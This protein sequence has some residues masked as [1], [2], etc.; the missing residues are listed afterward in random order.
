MKL[1]IMLKKSFIGQRKKTRDTVLSLGLKRI[2]HFVIRED[3][4]S[5]RGMIKKVNFMLSVEEVDEVK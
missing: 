2:H 4:P 5:I 3:T 1:K